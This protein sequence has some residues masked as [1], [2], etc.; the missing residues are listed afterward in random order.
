MISASDELWQNGGV[1]EEDA[2]SPSVGNMQQF[3]GTEYVSIIIFTH[4]VQADDLVNQ[5]LLCFVCSQ[6]VFGYSAQTS[7]SQVVMKLTLA[8]CRFTQVSAT[9][10]YM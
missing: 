9:I 7:A 1:R 4:L 8:N 3:E 2:V 5:H 10:A 6:R